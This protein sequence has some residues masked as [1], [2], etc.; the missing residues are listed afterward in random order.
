M[1]TT[2]P[3]PD[4][5]GLIDTRQQHRAASQ[6]RTQSPWCCLGETG[7]EWSMMDASDAPRACKFPERAETKGLCPWDLIAVG[8]F[9]DGER[10]QG[11]CLGASS[12]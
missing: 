7:T 6:L 5:K 2:A 3:A 11:M 9:H 1:A 8:G 12:T 4:N 10:V